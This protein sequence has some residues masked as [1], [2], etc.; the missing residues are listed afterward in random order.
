MNLNNLNLVELNA[1]EVQEVEG[2]YWGLAAAAVGGLALI[3]VAG[4]IFALGA[5]NGYHSA[6]K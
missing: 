1:Q 3:A 5:Y 2:G 6:A 4:G